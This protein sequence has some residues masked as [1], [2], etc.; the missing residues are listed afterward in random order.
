MNE[1]WSARQTITPEARRRYEQEHLVLNA[2]E[3]LSEVLDAEGLSSVELARTSG[4]DL[5][6]V[7]ALLGGSRE[8]TLRTLSD[9][10]F[11]LGY[12]VEISLEPLQQVESGG[13][14][15]SEAELLH[16]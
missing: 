12:R 14:S 4:M 16:G 2:T 3:A 8:L 9:L 6:H 13:R 1:A 15:Y 7:A 5:A 11:A 10:A